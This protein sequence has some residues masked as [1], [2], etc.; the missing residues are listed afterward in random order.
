MPAHPDQRKIAA[1][2]DLLGLTTADTTPGPC[3]DLP[4][5]VGYDILRELGKGGMGV[6]Y[7][8]RDTR[9]GRLVAIK[10]LPAH[11]SS[12]AS[13]LKRFEQ[14]AQSAAALNHQNW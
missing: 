7:R 6:V 14:E 13:R 11:L 12:D 9:L 1:M 2:L 5:V 4:V 3:A 8:A 10:V